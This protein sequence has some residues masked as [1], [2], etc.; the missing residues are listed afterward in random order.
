R[1][2]P[3]VLVPSRFTSSPLFTAA[4]ILG[5]SILAPVVEETAVRGY[6]QGTLERSVSPT[7]A[8]I[9]S[10]IVFAAAHVTQGTAWAKLL[11]YFLFGVTCGTMAGVPDSI[12]PVLPVHMTGDLLFFIVIWPFDDTRLP[13]AQSGFDR[14]FWLHVAQTI[15]C[16]GLA[17][18]AL[19]RA[20]RD[21]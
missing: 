5:A 1:M 14:S 16:G 13:I 18:I 21:H 20:R 19:H 8:I 12:L 10:S 4:I 17:A 3:N 11:F 9:L 7:T 15:V 6:L 2:E